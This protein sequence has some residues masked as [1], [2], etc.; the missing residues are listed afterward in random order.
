MQ[1]LFSPSSIAVVGASADPERVSGLP[2]KY[3]QDHGY[4]GDIYPVNPNHETVAGLPCYPDVGSVPE[5]P[6][7]VLVIVP[8]VLVVEVV[9]ESLERGVE[10]VLIV[11]SGFSETGTEEGMAAEERIAALAADHGA[12]VVG[13]DVS[14]GLLATARERASERG[15]S[16]AF[17]HG[18]AAR[19]PFADGTFSQ[20]LYVATLHHLRPRATRRRSLRE[21]G[22]VL[23]ADGRALVSAWST[24]HDRFDAEAG[25]DTTV[26]WTLPGGERV[27]RY[28]HIYDPA[29]F[30][31][32]IAAA[33]G[34][35]CVDLTVSSGNCYAVLAPDA[36][37]DGEASLTN[38]R[39]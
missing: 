14:R 7:L 16:A 33:A 28:Y 37:S 22:R 8:G 12:T 32:D 11:S 36:D 3:L 1:T 29:E 19:L 21:V 26:D 13:L 18:D 15:F 24:A 25:F 17:V 31:A 35:R 27:G 10:N 6:D 34:V 2:I 9:E 20:V 38:D 30:R 5:V 39:E 23:A 4:A